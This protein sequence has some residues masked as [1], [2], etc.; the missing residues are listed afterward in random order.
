MRYKNTRLWLGE[1]DRYARLRR[2]ESLDVQADHHE[3]A[4]LF[5][6]DFMSV[7]LTQSF[8]GFMLTFAAPRMSRI[9]A[10]TG[11]LEQRFAKRFVDTAL[12]TRAVMEHG[13]DPGMGRDAAR[14]VNAMHRHYD[15]HPDDF[16]MVACEEVMTPLT[17]A[18]RYGWRAVS[19][20]ERES[21]RLLQGH[22]ARAFGSP[23]PLPPTLGEIRDFWEN[24]L[25]TQLAFEPQNRRLAEAALAWHEALAPRPLRPLFRQVL[26][27]TL[28]PRVVR[29]CGFRVPSRLVRCGAHAFMRRLGQRDPIADDA[30]DPLREIVHTVYP[31][32]RWNVD[33]LGTHLQQGDCA[34]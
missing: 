16:L 19:D 2:I 14:R 4:V 15:I 32:G 9:L 26:L 34:R 30:P 11:E 20:R 7:M 12:L 27:A 25:D 33:T 10:A 24:Y 21:L 29:A 6:A 1:P 18:E 22:K 3:I 8:S 5:Y 31:E 17:L 13:L 23:R 28:D